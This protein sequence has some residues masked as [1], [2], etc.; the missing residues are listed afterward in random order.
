MHIAVPEVWNERRLRMPQG[1]VLHYSKLAVG[2][3]TWF[4][5]IPVTEPERTLLECV[6]EQVLPA[7]LEQA[8]SQALRPGLLENELAAVRS[9]LSDA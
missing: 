5:A 7:L 1:V 8:H 3:R 6:A 4:G 2:Q 9:Y